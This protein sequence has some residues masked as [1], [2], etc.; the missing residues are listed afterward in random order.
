MANRHEII[1]TFPVDG[2]PD[3]GFARADYV[4]MPELTYYGYTGSTDGSYAKANRVYRRELMRKAKAAM[5]LT[6]V[7]GVTTWNGDSAEFR[8]YGSDKILFID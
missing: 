3:M 4:D 7:R 5:D 8:P 6:G 2:L 1:F